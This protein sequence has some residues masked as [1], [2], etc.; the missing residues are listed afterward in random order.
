[1][2]FFLEDMKVKK[3]TK[4]KKKNS[5]PHVLNRASYS[6]NKGKKRRKKETIE[7]PHTHTHTKKKHYFSGVISSNQYMFRPKKRTKWM[8]KIRREESTVT[9]QVR[10][11]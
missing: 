11:N 3:F 7:L 4:K 8:R 9:N 6:N 2:P 10:G 5:K 1:M